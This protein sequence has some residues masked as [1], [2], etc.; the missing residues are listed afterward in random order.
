M[1]QRHCFDAGTIEETLDPFRTGTSRSIRPV[2]TRSA[3][4]QTV[5]A[6]SKMAPPFLRALRV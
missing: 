5:M 3:I 1:T 4:S 6:L 2:S